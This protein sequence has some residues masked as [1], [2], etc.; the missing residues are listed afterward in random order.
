MG[1]M[2][3]KDSNFI[4]G[5]FIRKQ[6]GES[7]LHTSSLLLFMQ[8][9][10]VSGIMRLT[11]A[12]HCKLADNHKHVRSNISIVGYPAMV[13]SK[14]HKPVHL[15]TY[16]TKAAAALAYNKPASAEVHQWLL[17]EVH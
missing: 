2:G 15:T 17:L 9:R 4:N 7:L 1:T 16:Q 10:C 13:W 14:L 3:P 6:Q 8:P 12:E 11:F 5:R